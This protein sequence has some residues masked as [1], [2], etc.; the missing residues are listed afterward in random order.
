MGACAVYVYMERHVLSRHRRLFLLKGGDI[1]EYTQF[2]LQLTASGTS[3]HRIYIGWGDT[4]WGTGRPMFRGGA[5]ASGTGTNLITP[6]NL[7]VD[8]QDSG[9]PYSYVV[10]DNI[11]LTGLYGN[12]AS[13][14]TIA[15][16]QGT[17]DFVS[18]TNNYAHGWK[19]GGSQNCQ[20]LYALVA[21]APGSYPEGPNSNASYNVVNGL[22]STGSGDCGFGIW[23]LVNSDHNVIGNIPDAVLTPV[24][25]CYHHDDYIFN[26]NAAYDGTHP[27]GIFCLGSG[28][29]VNNV[30]NNACCGEALSMGLQNGAYSNMV[31]N[32]VY[33][34]T[35]A[36]SVPGQLDN[37]GATTS[38]ANAFIANNTWVIGAGSGQVCFRV[39]YYSPITPTLGT[40]IYQ[41]NH[42]IGSTTQ[43]CYNATGS[44]CGNVT[45]P[46]VSNN[47]LMSFSEATTA[48]MTSSQTYVYSQTT[49][50]CNGISSADCPVGNATNLFSSMTG[51][52]AA[53]VNDTTYGVTYNAT[54]HTA[55]NSGRSTN[56]RWTSGGS[57]GGDTGAYLLSGSPPPTGTVAPC[58]ACFVFVPAP[59]TDV[60]VELVD[61]P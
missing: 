24:N 60:T 4:S 51:T 49:S 2:P 54:N 18:I 57:A 11:E 34:G 55:V 53:G 19:H 10:I 23:G 26:I 46:T 52:L 14:S 50:N 36:A 9:G 37:S 28:A 61:V 15:L 30:V 47:T 25:G 48:G 35:T 45:T 59:P 21:G 43:A 16:Y 44:G 58:P 29:L 8:L 31:D 17:A 33:G 22:D 32:V 3:G 5:G 42:C 6:N 13:A 40:F 41:N 39:D 56:V 7:F 1:W 12:S 38:T 20:N 27:D